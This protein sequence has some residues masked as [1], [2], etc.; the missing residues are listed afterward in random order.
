M[1]SDFPS[2]LKSMLLP[3]LCE[4]QGYTRIARRKTRYLRATPLAGGGRGRAPRP[5]A[6]EGHQAASE[7]RHA[8]RDQ[9]GRFLRG[10]VV[11]L[12]ASWVSINK[13]RCC[14]KS[15]DR[16]LSMKSPIFSGFELV[17]ERRG[18]RQTRA[19]SPE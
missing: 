7:Q 1:R 6:S 12:T 2:T 16:S 10:I 8:P 17:S 14:V 3:P 9:P 4:G 18:A 13:T 5:L 19:A 11:C 15:E